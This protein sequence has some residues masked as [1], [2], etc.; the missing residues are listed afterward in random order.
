ML[1]VHI[2]TFIINLS[3][4]ILSF[5][6]SWF[7][8]ALAM[9]TRADHDTYKAMLDLFS[10]FDWD[11]VIKLQGQTVS[12]D[13]SRYRSAQVSIVTSACVRSRDPLLKSLLPIRSE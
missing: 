12:E 7:T 4:F 10:R 1:A 3:L 5:Y 13:A 9:A 2:P 6:K 11:D 8:I